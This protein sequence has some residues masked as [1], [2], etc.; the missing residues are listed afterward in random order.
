[1]GVIAR[2][3]LVLASLGWMRLIFHF[4]TQAWGGAHTRN[5]IE[6]L[7]NA[8]NPGLLKILSLQQLELLNF[9]IRKLSHFTEYAVLACLGYLALSLGLQQPQQ[10]ALWL[11]LVCSTLYAFTDEFHQVFV[12]GRQAMLTDVLIDALGGLIAILL[13]KRLSL[14]PQSVGSPGVG[15]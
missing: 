1:M 4:S 15:H 5:L 7:L 12:P 6:V 9:L 2:L 8:A 13:L 3:G 14:H 11:A 10:R